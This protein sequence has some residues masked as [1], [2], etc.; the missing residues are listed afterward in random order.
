VRWRKVSMMFKTL[1]WFCLGFGS[2]ASIKEETPHI[3][4]QYS[5]SVFLIICCYSLLLGYYLQPSV[6]V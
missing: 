3:Q 4:S 1:P 5:R 6:C 2:L